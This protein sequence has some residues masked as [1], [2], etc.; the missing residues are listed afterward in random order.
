M[1]LTAEDASGVQVTNRY[2]TDGRIEQIQL[3]DGQQYNFYYS[4]SATNPRHLS[5]T[6]VTDSRHRSTEI[7]LNASDVDL[8][9]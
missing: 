8:E 6:L 1:M 3:S 9:D 7:R 4:A 5:Q 2:N